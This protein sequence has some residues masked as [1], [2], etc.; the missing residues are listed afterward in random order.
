MLWHSIFHQLQNAGTVLATI[1]SSGAFSIQR[2]HKSYSRTEVDLSLEQINNRDAASATKENVVLRNSKSIMRHWAW[3]RS[4]TTMAVGE[5]KRIPGLEQ[6]ENASAQVHDY[7]VRK[8]KERMQVI[9]S[10]TEDFEG[11]VFSDLELQPLMN[12]AAEKS[13]F[14]NTSNYLLR[15]LKR[16][17]ETHEKFTEEWKNELRI[18]FDQLKKRKLKI[19]LQNQQKA[20]LII[21]N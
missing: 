18:F 14:L 20:R 6:N 7:Q 9:L 4:Q 13:T 8:D 19:L 1:L 3:A 11:S 15:T 2:K 21:Y 10:T 5:L 12:L 16:G 17:K